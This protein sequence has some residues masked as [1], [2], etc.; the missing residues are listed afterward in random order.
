ML[1]ETDDTY[2]DA[3]GPED[4]NSIVEIYNSNRGFLMA[5]MA[6]ELVD[7]K[8]VEDEIETMKEIGFLSC[9]VVH[10]A[11]NAVIG[12]LDFAVK[13]ESYLSLLM[14]HADYRKLGFGTEVY[15]GFEYFAKA[16]KSIR[17]RIDVVTSNDMNVLDFWVSKGFCITENVELNWSGKTLPAVTMRKDIG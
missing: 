16:H 4:V 11:S 7:T 1:F 17:I 10:K 6:R 15:Q 2:I 8:W 9:K 3:A 5:H 13:E 14:L 12:V